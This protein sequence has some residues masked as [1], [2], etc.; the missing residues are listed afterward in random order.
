MDM[1]QRGEYKA[2]LEAHD[3]Q[4]QL[5]RSPEVNWYHQGEVRIAPLPWTDALTISLP[6]EGCEITVVDVKG[7]K[8]LRQHVGGAEF[9]WQ[10]AVPPGTY[11]LQ[12]RYPDGEAAFHK[13]LRL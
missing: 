11:Y 9:T 4:G 7:A 2:H 12:I 10:E 13:L 3:S 8:L 1:P 6:V 5:Q